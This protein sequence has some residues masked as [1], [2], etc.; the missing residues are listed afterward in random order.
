VFLAA[1]VA[2][3]NLAG[4]VAA[5]GRVLKPDGILIVGCESRD[6][7]GASQGLS[8]YDVLDRFEGKFPSVTMV[9][10]APFFG[11]ALVEYGVKDPEP[12]LDGM[13]VPKGERVE[14][15]LA[16][17]AKSGERRSAGGFALVQL[18]VMPPPA[19]ADA[20]SKPRAQTVPALPKAAPQ[21][22]PV[23]DETELGRQREKALAEFQAAAALHAKEMAEA[24][25]QLK[26]RDAYIFELERD[27]KEGILWHEQMRRVEAR[28]TAAEQRERQARLLLAQ[29]EGRFLGAMRAPS[30]EPTSTSNEPVAPT[31]TD[32]DPVARVAQLEAENA[33]LR[34]K[35]EEARADSWK[36]MKARA[37]AEQQVTAQREDTVR[38]MKD[39]RKLASVE[40]MRAMEEATKK[41]VSLKDELAR[42]ERERKDSKARIEALEAEIA[43]LRSDKGVP[44]PAS[45]PSTV[46]LA[47]AREEGDAAVLAVRAAAAQSVH[48]EELARAAADLARQRDEERFDHLRQTVQGLEREVQDKRAEA[49]S[50]QG[51]LE[52]ERLKVNSLE[53]RVRQAEERMAAIAT[54][55][56][57]MA[58]VPP[59]SELGDAR[60]SVVALESELAGA[61]LGVAELGMRLERQEAAME[62]TAAALAHERARAERLTSDERRAMLERGQLASRVAELEAL[63]RAEA[64]RLEDPRVLGLREELR[65]LELAVRREVDHVASIEDSLR[66]L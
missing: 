41:A 21:T 14:W 17:A 31:P 18:P 42:T 23:T 52:A 64:A 55:E 43:A 29:S 7:P 35:E 66:R 38:K 47:R 45:F 54:A 10:Q 59:D 57:V 15:Y 19:V 53:E 37:E 3:S 60:T 34:R 49:M 58:S 50:R 24:K 5:A 48:D 22:A 26:E 65:T 63:L 11:A 28:A 61:R 6:R 20:R 33:K 1:D 8:Y 36:H 39:A 40:L 12:L 2:A 32:L 30:S 51:E 4:V 16:I 56:R 25:T 27:A 13:L 62:R 46:D 44:A 9:G